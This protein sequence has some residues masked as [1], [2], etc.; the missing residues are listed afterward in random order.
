MLHILSREN[1]GCGPGGPDKPETRRPKSE[2]NPKPEIR[3]RTPLAARAGVLGLWSS[4]AADQAPAAAGPVDGS[5]ACNP[6]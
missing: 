2:G 6:Q 5:R 1:I 3:R 4:R